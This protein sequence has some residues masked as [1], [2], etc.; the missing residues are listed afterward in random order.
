MRKL[1]NY[2]SNGPGYIT[3]AEHRKC[4]VMFGL[5]SILTHAALQFLP[6]QEAAVVSQ[7]T[8]LGLLLGALGTGALIGSYATMFVERKQ[9]AI[10]PDIEAAPEASV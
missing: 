8:L 4:L 9:A 1:A 3:K 7:F 10:G 2:I 6:L 5:F